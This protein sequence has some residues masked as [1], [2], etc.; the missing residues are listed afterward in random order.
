MASPAM[1]PI[2]PGLVDPRRPG[3]YPIILGDSLK[4]DGKSNKLINI[5]YNWQPKSGFQSRDSQLT[6]SGDKYSLVVQGDD[7]DDGEYQ[8][9]G[10]LQPANPGK[11]EETSRS[12]ALVFDKSKSVFVLE[13]LSA[14]LDLNL[15]CG[16]GQPARDARELPQLS[17]DRQSSKQTAQA[18]VDSSAP[19]SPDDEGPDPSNPYDFRNFLAEARENI[20]K[21][22]QQQQQGNRTPNPGGMTP[23]SGVSTPVPGSSRF[24]PTTPQFRPTTK[25]INKTDRSSDAPRARASSGASKTASKRDKPSTSTTKSSTQQPLSKE[26]ITDS[27]D[28]SDDDSTSLAVSRGRDK[29]STSATKP[30]KPAQPVRK[31]QHSRNISSTNDASPHII[32]N[33]ND[34]DLEIDMGSPP[35]EDRARRTRV[36]PEMFRSHTGTPIAGL[37]SNNNSARPSSSS[38]R[39]LSRLNG[40]DSAHGTG[41][42]DRDRDRDVRMKDIEA[43][44]SDDEDGDVEEFELGSPQEKQ[45]APRQQQQNADPPAVAAAATTAAA[46]AEDEDDEGFLEA[47]LEAAFGEEDEQ[48]GQHS[49]VGLGI[50]MNA[51]LQ[52]QDDESEVSE[53]E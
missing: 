18:N 19:P 23:L 11:N 34:G 50:G 37:S 13:S 26:R 17:S 40:M 29:L 10:T 5:R 25:P 31:A 8:Y 45:S 15:K 9:R 20:D 44:L 21:T 38:A 3:E 1:H 47:A 27:D 39:P 16:P 42:G 6:E 53:E 33:D 24:K 4:T 52:Q 48:A 2:R 12:L 43:D 28:D 46:A 14:S 22:S 32:I 30:T 41:S 35:P 36:D 51:Q 49:G 7:S